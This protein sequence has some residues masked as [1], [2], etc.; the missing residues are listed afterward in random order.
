MKALV[1][2]SIKRFDWQVSK[3]VPEIAVRGVV[4]TV[5]DVTPEPLTIRT[6]DRYP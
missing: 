1:L 5:T 3:D 2:L 4:G 6:L